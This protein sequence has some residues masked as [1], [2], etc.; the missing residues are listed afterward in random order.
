MQESALIRYLYT[1]VRGVNAAPGDTAGFGLPSLSNSSGDVSMH[2]LAVQVQGARWAC[3]AHAA[4]ASLL[5]V[6][7]L[8]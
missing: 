8:A 5:L 4:M 2:E 6:P 3:T 7:V 1:A